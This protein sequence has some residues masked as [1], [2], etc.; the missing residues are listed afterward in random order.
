[1]PDRRRLVGRER[2]SHLSAELLHFLVVADA[3][4]VDRNLAAADLGDGG[5]PETAENIANA[6]DPEADDQK[7]DHRRHDDLAEPIGRGFSQT[8]KHERYIDLSG[9]SGRGGCRAR[10]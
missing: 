2:P 9:G 7:P 10:A 4:L 1:M 5:D 3:E 8:S 6:P